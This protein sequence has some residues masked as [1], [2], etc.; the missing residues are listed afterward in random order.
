MMSLGKDEN[1]AGEVGQWWNTELAPVPQMTGA[2]IALVSQ[3]KQTASSSST[4]A[5]RG[6]GATSFGSDVIWLVERFRKFTPEQEGQ[7]R[8][9][10]K[11]D[12]EGVLPDRLGYLLG[13]DGE[14]R[15]VLRPMDEIPKG[16]PADEVLLELIVDLL[17]G[18]EA[19]AR[20]GLATS[21]I[22]KSIEGYGE[23]KIKTALDQLEKDEKVE[24]YVN[25]GTG[26]GVR[27]RLTMAAAMPDAP[28][29]PPI[30]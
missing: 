10:R 29:A 13:G 27:W 9:T 22:V 24:H 2:T 16:E 12:R 21:A 8:L 14:D 17:E 11:K 3:V 20:G 23:S 25:T 26:G 7:I 4:Y 15:I 18:P 1:S 6:T 5:Q 30:D 28:D 19:E